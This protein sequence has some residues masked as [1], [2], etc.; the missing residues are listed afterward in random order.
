[1][2]DGGNVTISTSNL[3]LSDGGFVSSSTLGRGNAGS[4]NVTATGDIALQGSDS[5][6]SASGVSSQVDSEAVGDGG[7]VTISTGNLSLT[8]G[9]F[10][11]SST[12]GRGN[13]G[14]VNVTATRDLS[15]EDGGFV[16]SSTFGRGNA[17]SVNVT[18][19]GDLSLQGLD[20]DGS[21]SRVSSQVNPEAV[22]DGGDV[23]I[24]TNN[25]SLKDGGFVSSNTL[26]RGNAGSVN[27]T[28]TGDLSLEGANSGGVASRV[29]SQVSSEAVGNG[30]NVIISTNN[31]SLNGGEINANNASIQEQENSG[32][33]SIQANSIALNQGSINAFSQS[34]TV[35]NANINLQIAENI[36]LDNNS[37][38]S[39]EARGNANGGNLNID[40]EFIIAV[41]N[42][43][44]DIIANAQQG[45]GG[46]IDIDVRSLLGIKERPL[47]DA[48]NDINASSEFDSSGTVEID[49]IETDPGDNSLNIP[50]APVE[51]EV[52]QTCK[53]NSNG[54]Q[55]ELVVTGRGGLP[56]TPEANLS[57]SF[58][59]EDWRVGERSESVTRSPQNPL[60]NSE[61]Q[62]EQIVEADSWLVDRQGKVVLVANNG[63]GTSGELI[64][65]RKNCPTQSVE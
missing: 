19:T 29:S 31:L 34:A 44:S 47:R 32:N 53:P 35:D 40:A 3:S 58:V 49:I 7:D 5:D 24:S 15:L 4:V 18:A 13:A 8:D 39:A 51:T 38:I 64:Q 28:A 60:P 59:I 12:F 52:A 10:V 63:A 26:G 50:V 33:I 21:A 1:M 46:N 30:G 48:T 62:T 16:S 23:T 27:V 65:Q 56:D 37:L 55:S 57:S 20:S 14:S 36:I 9:G 17:G 43:N 22:G 54:N 61:N 45:Q 11:S 42:S 41:P 25:L 6:G 2:G